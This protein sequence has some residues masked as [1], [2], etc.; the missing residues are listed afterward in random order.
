MTKNSASKIAFGFLFFFISFAV[1]AQP[2]HDRPRLV[3]G[4]MIDGLQQEHINEFWHHFGTRSLKMIIEDGTTLSRVRYNIVSAGNASDVATVMTGTTPKFHGVAGNQFFNRR[5]GREESILFD[6]NQVGIG[7][8]HAFSARNLLA[9]T[10]VDELVLSNAGRSRVHVVAIEPEVAIMMGGHTARSV[11]WIDD[12][13]TRWVTTGYYSEGLSRHADRMNIDGTFANI[14]DTRWQ[15]LFAPNSYVWNFEGT[16]RSFDHR[17]STRRE[18]SASQTI[19]RNTPSANTLVTELAMTMIREERLGRNARHTDM[20][21]LQYTVRTPNEMFSSVKS[22]E[23]EDMYLRLDRE[24]QRLMERIRWDV[25]LENTLIFVFPNISG[26]HTPLELGNNQIP[27]GY[28]NANR[29]IALLNT[30]LMAIYGQERWVEGYSGKNIFLNRRLIEE[31]RLNLQEMQQRTADFMIE[32][33]GVRAA[34][35]SA[36]ILN[37]PL[38]NDRDAVNIRN[39]F[40]KR[41]GGDV[42]ISLLPGWLEV[43]NANNP[44]GETTSTNTEVPVYF[45][46][47]RIPAQRINRVLDITDIAPTLSFILGIPFPNA[48]LGNP[49]EELMP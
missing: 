14:A 31:R 41:S 45:Y 35:T 5:T 28:F 25:G 27:S 13:F 29:S 23:K 15:P 44:I 12:V 46:G 33:E 36:Q 26:T 18:R 24:I 9:S 42:V 30:Y 16:N 38:S 20:L 48:N 4:I 47:W 22:M 8:T 37:Q 2:T 3:V 7:T 49:I 32:F 6:P 11:A 43:D 39:S 40:H 21:L 17:P 19:L 1:F 10:I 34:F